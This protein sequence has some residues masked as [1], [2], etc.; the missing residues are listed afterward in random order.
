MG[1][2]QY[3]KRRTHRKVAGV[4]ENMTEARSGERQ[5]RQRGTEH[6]L[7][8]VSAGVVGKARETADAGDAAPR[9]DPREGL[10]ANHETI[11]RNTEA[12]SK[13]RKGVLTPGARRQCK[14]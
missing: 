6:A 5:G 14:A 9:R 3:V 12:C 1:N 7:R 11:L 13:G 4:E 10:G 2:G 8:R